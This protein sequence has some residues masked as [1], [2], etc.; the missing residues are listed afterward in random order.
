MTENLV[1]GTEGYA[2]HAEALASRWDA[3][4]FAELHAP[5]LALL[6][7]RSARVLDIGAGSGRDAA[8][9][10]GMGY[11]VVAVE[12]VAALRSRAAERHSS[13]RIAW[14]DD[15]LPHLATLTGVAFD[16][17]MLT[18]VWMHL[19]APQR[20]QAIRRTA[21]LIA[22][23]GLMSMSLRHGPLP[24]NR[25]M[26]DV[27]A[28]ETV[29]LAMAHGLNVCLQSTSNSVQRANRDAGV[30]WTRLAFRKA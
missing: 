7:A 14:V 10:A 28:D 27:S 1:P 26:F 21:S 9:F 3:I 30:T 18:A 8:A 29:A 19:D 23:G 24:G 11:Q 15:S 2:E 25:R 16:V 13:P 4:S 12:P 22:P 5:I 6:P 20:A 17:V